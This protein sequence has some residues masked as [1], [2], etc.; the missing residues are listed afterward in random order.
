M[1]VSRKHKK[2]DGKRQSNGFKNVLTQSNGQTGGVSGQNPVIE[3]KVRKIFFCKKRGHLENDFLKF[4]AWSSKNGYNGNDSLTLLLHESNLA[5]ALSSSW[6][7]DISATTHVA[8]TLQGLTSKTREN[9]EESKLVV[10]NNEEVDF[11]FI[12]VVC[13]N[14]DSGFRLILNSTF[15]VPPFR[16]NLVLVSLLDKEGYALETKDSLTKLFLNS[17]DIGT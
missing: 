1:F 4:K 17:K 8:F 6:W 13:L 3:K 10:A 11:E 12:R 16:P 7:L 5:M 15:Y 2:K 14:L 9:K